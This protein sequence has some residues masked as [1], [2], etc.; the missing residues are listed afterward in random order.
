[1]SVDG[2]RYGRQHKRMQV[3][4]RKRKSNDRSRSQH[5]HALISLGEITTYLKTPTRMDMMVS[6]IRRTLTVGERAAAVEHTNAVAKQASEE[7]RRRRQE[8][9][10]RLRQLRLAAI[11]NTEPK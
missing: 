3:E 11:G 5:S 7:E 8:K 1:M 4:R 10:E 2:C 6:R 9:T